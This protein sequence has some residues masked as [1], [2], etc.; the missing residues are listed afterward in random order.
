[1]LTRL[2]SRYVVAPPPPAGPC[3]TDWLSGACLMVRREVFDAVGLLDEGYFLYFEEVDF[4]RRAVRAGWSCWYVP[5]ARVVHRVGS[6]TG[7]TT[8]RRRPRYWFDSRRRYF[9][10]HLGAT[11]TLL[12]DVLWTTG[13]ATF[14][15]RRPLQGKPDTDPKHLL[16]DFV[17][18]NLLSP[19]AP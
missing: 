19:G 4:C 15:L 17:R 6:S 14:R 16:G 18:Y 2:L 10:R 1:M 7:W 12:A 9:R 13:Y 11:K 8:A 3:R 5:A